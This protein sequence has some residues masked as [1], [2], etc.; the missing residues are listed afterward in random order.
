MARYVARA[1]PGCVA[2]AVLIAAVPPIMVLSAKSPWR[3]AD[4][5]VRRLLIGTGG[6]PGAVLPGCTIGPLLRFQSSRSESLEVSSGVID[7]WWR[8]G[9]MGGAKAHYDYAAAYSETDF[10]KDLKQITGSLYRR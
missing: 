6:Q 10:T 1:K 3:V 7:N 2:K 5:G 4:R 8:Q 9:T